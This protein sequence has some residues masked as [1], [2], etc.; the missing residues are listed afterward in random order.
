MIASGLDVFCQKKHVNAPKQA[1]K[2]AAA[3]KTRRKIR[4]SYR[5]IQPRKIE[6][7]IAP[8][9]NPAAKLL[10]GFICR[11]ASKKGQKATH[12]SGLKEG[13]VTPTTAKPMELISCMSWSKDMD[14]LYQKMIL[15]FVV[16]LDTITLYY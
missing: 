3:D 6:K 1:K 12:K 8:T 16:N 15:S 11:I 10:R 13:I 7:K 5:V 9:E 14:A 4:S 2:K